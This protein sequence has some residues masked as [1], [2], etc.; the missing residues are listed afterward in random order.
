MGTDTRRPGHRPGH[1]ERGRDARATARRVLV[2]V[3]AALAC[4]VTVVGGS[5]ASADAM[6]LT[7]VRSLTPDTYEARV[8]TWI[9]RERVAHGLPRVRAHTCTDRYAERWSHYL[10]RRLAFFHQDLDPFFSRCHARYAGETLARGA[11]SPREMV[12][13]WMHS[14]GHRAILLSRHPRRIGVGAFLDARGDWL[15]AADFTRF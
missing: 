5:A 15:V 8:V 12:Q 4:A 9:N 7:S 11:V 3:L 13:L 14:D 2:A 1:P 6:S 10:G